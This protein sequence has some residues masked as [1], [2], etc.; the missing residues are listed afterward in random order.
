MEDIN[1]TL[2]SLCE[3]I[4]EKTDGTEVLVKPTDAEVDAAAEKLPKG[5]HLHPTGGG[6][7]GRVLMPLQY[8]FDRGLP[9]SIRVNKMC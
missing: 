5:L 6:C 8:I 9:R 7:L 1:K 3:E 2:D 4:G